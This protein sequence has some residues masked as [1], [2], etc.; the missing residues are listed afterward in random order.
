MTK[1]I[2]TVEMHNYP[3]LKFNGVRTEL[4]LFHMV[5]PFRH[6]GGGDRTLSYAV[7][8]RNRAPCEE[9]EEFFKIFADFDTIIVT[10][11]CSE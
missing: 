4:I 5:P 10:S 2:I 7:V 8:L 11:L 3:P 6:L 1:I 9:E